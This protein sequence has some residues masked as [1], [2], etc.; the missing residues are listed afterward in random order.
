MSAVVRAEHL[1]L[2]DVPGFY[3]LLRG[4]DT[5]QELGDIDGVVAHETEYGWLMWVPDDPDSHAGADGPD[6]PAEVLIVQRYAR[7]HDCDYVLFDNSADFDDQLPCWD[8]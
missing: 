6:I 4:S 2:H 1:L 8:W 7:G 3:C 5:C